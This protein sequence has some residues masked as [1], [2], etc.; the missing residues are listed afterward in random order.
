MGATKIMIIRHAEKPDTYCKKAYSGVSQ[1]GSKCG[2]AGDECLVTLGWERAGALVT[3][4]ASPWGPKQQSV[5]DASTLL[6]PTT[7]FASNP[8][9]GKSTDTAAKAGSS[10][11]PSQRP[12]ETLLAVAAS[13]GTN[14]EPMDI[15]F[16][17]AKSDY[18]TMVKTALACNGAILIA[19][20]H[21][22]IL[23]IG[24]SILKNTNTPAKDFPLPT[25]WP[26]SRYDMVWV[27][28]RPTG[29]NQITG[30]SI[31]Y[32]MLLAGDSATPPPM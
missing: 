19:W 13:L 20:Q 1:H 31:F 29:A 16:D 7:L 25:S 14:C 26:G 27:F 5:P 18:D 30:F 22:D 12:F 32:Q 8:D 6:T 21:E 10:D 15:N 3:L 11:E 17:Y 28:D 9:K 2:K 23:S 4:F 24:Q